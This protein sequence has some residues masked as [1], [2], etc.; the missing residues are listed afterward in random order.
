MSYPYGWSQRFQDRWTKVRSDSSKSLHWKSLPSEAKFQITKDKTLFSLKSIIGTW[1]GRQYPVFNIIKNKFTFPYTNQKDVN[2]FIDKYFK[3]DAAVKNSLSDKVYQ[4]TGIKK[5]VVSGKD[6][7]GAKEI[8]VDSTKNFVELG[9][10]TDWI[11]EVTSGRYIGTVL[12]ILEVISPTEIKVNGYQ[13]N[14]DSY[15]LIAPL[16]ITLNAVFSDTPNVYLYPANEVLYNP[17]GVIPDH[18]THRSNYPDLARR[19]SMFAEAMTLVERGQFLSVLN[20]FT[21]MALYKEGISLSDSDELISV[22]M[23]AYAHA[24]VDP[25]RKEEIL[26]HP[27][28]KVWRAKIDY[29]ISLISNDSD[30]FAVWFEGTYYSPNTIKMLMQNAMY[31]EWTTGKD[32]FP[33]LTKRLDQIAEGAKVEFIPGFRSMMQWSDTQWLYDVINFR[34]MDYLATAMDIL[35]IK[36]GKIDPEL[37]YLREK[38]EPPIGSHKID[39]PYLQRYTPFWN[40]Y[41]EKVDDAYWLN[42]PSKVYHNSR[43]GFVFAFSG[44]NPEKD[45][46]FFSSAYPGTGFDHNPNSDNIC[47]W[48]RGEWMIDWM[49]GYPSTDWETFYNCLAPFGEQVAF[50][51]RGEVYFKSGKNWFIQKGTRSGDFVKE[52]SRTVYYY[53]KEFDMIVIVDDLDVPELPTAAKLLS[54]RHEEK[55]QMEASGFR[56]QINFYVP[57]SDVNKVH[58]ALSWYGNSDKET[59]VK[60]KQKTIVNVMMPEDSFTDELYENKLFAGKGI[61]PWIDIGSN[62]IENIRGYSYRVVPKQQT[63]KIRF[64]YVIFGAENELLPNAKIRENGIDF[65]SEK[66]N[67]LI[68]FDNLTMDIGNTFPPVID[69]PI[70]VV[71]E[72]MIN[73]P[74]NIKKLNV[75][76]ER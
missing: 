8:V 54:Y 28:M 27:L 39:S 55:A 22:Y 5:T 12:R 21:D 59:Y 2:N 61:S 16:Q 6:Q 3:V 35:E 60:G 65:I 20:M 17:T 64:V 52:Q 38:I 4:I 26:N 18:N 34:R 32:E 23:G 68:N 62:K 57:T 67:V 30:D 70:P 75:S 43:L 69:P 63:G 10:T 45:S 72:M 19:Y 1:A 44:W 58:G 48:R 73:V 51:T 15:S 37:G 24:L 41:A 9:V 46:V 14:G 42:K 31:I 74:K 25:T 11:F 76:I 66:E 7:G 33:E 29:M 47:L 53:R 71:E 40:P 56:H 50:A 49:R 36:T 13:L